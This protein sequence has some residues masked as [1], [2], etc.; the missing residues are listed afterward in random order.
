MPVSDGFILGADLFQ[1]FV[2]VLLG[3]GIDLHIDCA[4]KLRAQCCQL[5][6]N[7]KE[8]GS[9]LYD[10]FAEFQTAPQVW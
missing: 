7:G 3:C 5:L 10:L 9:Q 1:D 6:N 8:E 2:E 4:S